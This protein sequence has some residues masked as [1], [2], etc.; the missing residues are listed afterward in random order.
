MFFQWS[1]SGVAAAV[2]HQRRDD[3]SRRPTDRR[4]RQVLGRADLRP[5]EPVGTV[6][7]AT[8][9]KAGGVGDARYAIS[10]RRPR[11]SAE[12]RR[13]PDWVCEVSSSST[14]RLD[15]GPEREVYRAQGAP[16]I[17]LVEPLDELI[18]VLKLD[19]ETYRVMMTATGD[20]AVRLPPF[21][22]I[23]LPLS[24]LWQ[25][26]E[27]AP[28][29]PADSRICAPQERARNRSRRRAG[30]RRAKMRCPGPFEG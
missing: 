18:E 4:Q 14:R 2:L 24:A 11:S 20:D 12:I 22:A 23:E 28:A 1:W 16:W 30:A 29:A 13:G 26:R 7:E 19:G 3:R 17:W 5:E 8:C 6:T 15:R 27:L 10:T 9:A 21:D 25:R